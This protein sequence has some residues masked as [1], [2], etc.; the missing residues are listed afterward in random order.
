MVKLENKLKQTKK[1]N[2]VDSYMQAVIDRLPPNVKLIL[3]GSYITIMKELL[4]G[5]SRYRE[6]I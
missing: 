1:Q 5:R 2:E 3:C 4:T 6:E